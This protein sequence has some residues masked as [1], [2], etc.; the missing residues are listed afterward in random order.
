MTRFLKFTSSNGEQTSSANQELIVG[1]GTKFHW[2]QVTLIT[3]ADCDL[4]INEGLPT[5]STIKVI[6]AL[7][8]TYQDTLIYSLKIKQAGIQYYYNAGYYA[9]T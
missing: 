9:R 4:V 5:E 7:S 3:R 2:K 8:F 1:E 6:P